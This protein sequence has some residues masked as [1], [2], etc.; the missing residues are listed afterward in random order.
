MLPASSISD[1]KFSIKY[2]CF[3]IVITFS[4]WI[5]WRNYIFQIKLQDTSVCRWQKIDTQVG[6]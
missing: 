1:L 5:V 4:S 2:Y 6:W 3:L